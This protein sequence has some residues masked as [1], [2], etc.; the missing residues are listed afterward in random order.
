[1]KL[2]LKEKIDQEYEVVSGKNHIKIFSPNEAEVFLYRPHTPPLIIRIEGYKNKVIFENSDNNK[3]FEIPWSKKSFLEEPDDTVF[4]ITRAL[5]K[6][7]EIFEGYTKKIDKKLSFNEAYSPDE[8]M[9]Y[10]NTWKNYNEYG[11]DLVLYDN[12]DGWMSI[13]DAIE[14]AEEHAEDEPFINDTDNIPSAF[15]IDEYSNVVHTLEM[16]KRFEDSGADIDILEAIMDSGYNTLEDALDKYESGDYYW[17]PG[18]TDYTELAYRLIDESGGLEYALG[19]R[20]SDYI[21]EEQM[22]RDYEDDVREMMRDDAKR[23]VYRAHRYDDEDEYDEEDEIQDWIDK[24]IDSYLQSVIN[25]D[26]EMAERGEI[27]LSN[28]FDYE[29][30]GRDLSYDGY[31]ITDSGTILC[32]GLNKKMKKK[33]VEWDL[34]PMGTRYEDITTIPINGKM[35]HIGI[36]DETQGF[37]LY[38]RRNDHGSPKISVFKIGNKL[39]LKNKQG[40]IVCEVPFYGNILKNKEKFYN[41]VVDLAEKAGLKES[42]LSGVDKKWTHDELVD[43]E[44]KLW[45]FLKKKGATNISFDGTFIPDRTNRVDVILDGYLDGDWKHE[46][47][48]FKHLIDEFAEENG[49]IIVNKFS[50]VTR[51]DGSDFY[52]AHYEIPMIL[53]SEKSQKT[54]NDFRKFFG[55]SKKISKKSCINNKKNESVNYYDGETKLSQSERRVLN[56]ICRRYCGW[57]EPKEIRGLWEEL[58]EHGIDVGIIGGYPDSV[59][60]DGGKSWTVTFSKDDKLVINSKFVYQVYEPVEGSKNEYNMYFS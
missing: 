13:D 57:K 46:H 30:F 55:E 18:V 56:S 21:D 10:M 2:M 31:V 1:M 9:V 49:F 28:Y 60:P 15:G 32:E 53:K 25:D 12:I 41:A 4:M 42:I 51:D 35:A 52:E 26:I 38:G 6:H 39:V 34:T 17:Y 22:K 45:D 16:L 36:I 48:Y 14:F 7:K 19:D 5:N 47:L 29:K 8:M 20:V 3:Y 37:I 24:N 40:K 59:A 43:L 58:L 23:E 27:D 54:L 44:R 50:Q 11:A 33:L